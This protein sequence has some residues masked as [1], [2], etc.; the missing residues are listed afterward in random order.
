MN[1]ILNAFQRYGNIKIPSKIEDRRQGDL[2]H[3]YTSNK[4]AKKLL[5]WRPSRNLNIMIKD[6]LK[7]IYN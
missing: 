1:D 2:S 6:L 3:Y 7:F 5:D 4:K